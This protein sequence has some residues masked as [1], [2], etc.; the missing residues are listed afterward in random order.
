[1]PTENR[2]RFLSF[3]E[4]GRSERGTVNP[5]VV[6]SSPTGPTKLI[7]ILALWHMDQG[8]FVRD[9]ET[10]SNP[11]AANSGGTDRAASTEFMVT[12][13]ASALSFDDLCGRLKMGALRDT[14]RP[15]TA[16]ALPM[17]S[18]KKISW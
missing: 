6:G 13:T 2:L 4:L 3:L 5:L 10:P 8:I 17:R 11:S 12:V 1:M 7:E 18:R 14:R 9:Q 16:A 15:E